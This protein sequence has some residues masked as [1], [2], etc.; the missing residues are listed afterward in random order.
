M[1]TFLISGWIDVITY[2]DD[3]WAGDHERPPAMAEQPWEA[4]PSVL[5][6]LSFCFV[7]SRQHF[8]FWDVSIVHT[9]TQ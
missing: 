4:S 1:L 5:V 9:M 2:V 8:Y 7:L 6:V 3:K